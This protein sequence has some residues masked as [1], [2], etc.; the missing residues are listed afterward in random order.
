MEINFFEPNLTSFIQP[1]DAGII[2][3]FKAHYRKHF[4]QHAI[5][6]DAAR[7]HDIYSIDLKEGMELAKAVTP[8]GLSCYHA[9]SCTY[10]LSPCVPPDC[11]Y[12]TIIA[13]IGLM[14]YLDT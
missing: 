11:S 10:I 13:F 12:Q 1:L 2:R 9:P 5:D 6:L 8:L 14:R 3:C 4:C 7:I